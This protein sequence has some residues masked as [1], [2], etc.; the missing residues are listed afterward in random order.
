MAG[1]SEFTTQD[2]DAIKTLGQCHSKKCE[3]E[4]RHTIPVMGI[5]IN[6][7]FD[8]TENNIFNAGK[9][10]NEKSSY[11][12]DKSNIGL[13]YEALPSSQVKVYLDGIGTKRYQS[14][15]TVGKATGTGDYGI[16]ARVREA[17]E[18][19]VEEANQKLNGTIP[20]YVTLN[21]F[22][23]SRGAAAARNFVHLAN[24]QPELFKNA[25]LDKDWNFAKNNPSKQNGVSVNFV[26]LFDTVASYGKD[27]NFSNDTEQLHL[28]FDSGYANKVVH[29]VA[30]DEYRANFPLTNIN[31]ALGLSARNGKGKMGYE[32]RIPGA[33]SDV[34]GGYLS[35]TEQRNLV[36]CAQAQGVKFTQFV[37]SK[38]WYTEAQHQGRGWFARRINPQFH[39][40]A[41]GIMLDKIRKYAQL[42]I[43]QSIAA[44]NGSDTVSQTIKNIQGIVRQWAQ[45]ESHTIWDLDGNPDQDWAKW[46]RN[47]A[48]HLSIN[49]N[50]SEETIAYH[51][52]G[53]WHGNQL[54]RQE[55]KG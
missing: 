20:H 42:N 37:Y 30:L 19:S 22:G 9:R 7:F 12:G 17:F 44:V 45:D 24:T 26:G 16:D 5:T 48:L 54:K 3:E 14:D 8:G 40:V 52:S 41:L 21:V 53:I 36:S 50:D 13:M 15:S 46:V 43:S 11:G 28:N 38:G 27:L 29:L 2:I 39:K 47:T 31:S 49:Y 1:N 6:V 34:G 25:E 51:A 10:P 33:H 35:W 23:F 4:A 18:R 55:H 32:L